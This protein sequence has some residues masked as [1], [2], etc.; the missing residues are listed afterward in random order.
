[1]FHHFSIILEGNG[2]LPQYQ[3]PLWN[4]MTWP[5]ANFS[6][7]MDAVW[8]TETWPGA[9]VSLPTFPQAT[10]FYSLS[11]PRPTERIRQYYK[12]CWKSRGVLI[13]SGSARKAVEGNCEV[14]SIVFSAAAAALAFENRSTFGRKITSPLLSFL[15]G[16]MLRSKV[17]PFVH[18]MY[19]GGITLFICNYLQP[20]FSLGL[21][22]ARPTSICWDIVLFVSGNDIEQVDKNS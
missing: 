21:S 14:V 2:A 17:L 13:E 12:N 9:M 18:P 1:M 10:P 8:H 20:L 22:C 6:S 11:P 19:F 4:Q 7:S 5:N 15:I 3:I 16:W